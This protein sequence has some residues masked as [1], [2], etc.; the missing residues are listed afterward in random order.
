MDFLSVFIFPFIKINFPIWAHILI[1][2][3]VFIYANLSVY[4]NLQK[5]NLSLKGKIRENESKQPKLELF[6]LDKND[7]FCSS[8]DIK[9]KRITKPDIDKELEREGDIR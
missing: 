2:I 1:F 4:Y 8:M 3:L 9:V 5:E 6:M 7:G